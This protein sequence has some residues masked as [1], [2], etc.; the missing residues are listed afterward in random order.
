[1]TKTFMMSIYGFPYEAAHSSIM[2]ERMVDAHYR[3]LQGHAV[4]ETISKYADLLEIHLRSFLE[5]RHGSLDGGEGEGEEE[6]DLAEV[7][8]D[9]IYTA[10][11]QAFFSPSFPSHATIR[12]FLAF[13]DAVPVLALGSLPNILRRS[14]VSKRETLKDCVENWLATITH[15]DLEMMFSGERNNLET[16]KSEGWAVRDRVGLVLGELWALEANAPYAAIWT[17]VEILRDPTLLAEIREEIVNAIS[18]QVPPTLSTLV[19]LSQSQLLTTLP[20]INATIQETLRFHTASFSLRVVENDLTLPLPNGTGVA[21]AAGEEVVVATRTCQ[22]DPAGAWGDDAAVW[23]GKRFLRKEKE[24]GSM[25]PFGGGTTIVSR[26]T[27][28]Q[29]LWQD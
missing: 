10:S 5:G 3:D 27:Q 21:L 16:A 4:Y 11:S 12:P 26:F 25:T 8:Y 13:D 7:L 15:E 14:A 2:E 9:I 23:D 6:V 20:L 19:H 29:T 17:I 18:T 28:S 24:R 22:I 1:M